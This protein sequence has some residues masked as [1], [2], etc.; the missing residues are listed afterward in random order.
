MNV[1]FASECNSRL[2]ALNYDERTPGP[3]V[4]VSY[5]I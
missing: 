3:K 1:M 2:N 4:K 5:F